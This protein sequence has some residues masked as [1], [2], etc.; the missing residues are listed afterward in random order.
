MQNGAGSC[1]DGEQKDEAGTPK[2][3][4]SVCATGSSEELDFE[5]SVLLSEP[6]A[7]CQAAQRSVREVQERLSSMV[8]QHSRVQDEQLDSGN[9]Q[10]G[11]QSQMAS[12]GQQEAAEVQ[13]RSGLFFIHFCLEKVFNRFS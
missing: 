2:S 1:S 12:A 4:E 10:E 13:Q 7:A 9:T 5:P 11:S 3:K 6:H 8:L